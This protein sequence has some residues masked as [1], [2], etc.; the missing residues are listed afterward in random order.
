MPDAPSPNSLARSGVA[1]KSA[2]AI[3]VAAFALAAAL[4][5]TGC[6]HEGRTYK[7][8]SAEKLV[9]KQQTATRHIAEA[10]KQFR[11]ASVSLRA[12][13]TSHTRALAGQ[14]EATRRLALLVPAVETLALKAPAELQAEFADLSA[15]V[16]ALSAEVEKNTGEMTATAQLLRETQAAQA[17]GTANLEQG[18]AAIHEINST[19]APAHFADVEKLAAQATAASDREADWHNKH[20]ALKRQSWTRRIL[21]IAAAVAVLGLVFLW[22]SARIAASGARAA[23]AAASAV[24]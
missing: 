12:A 15:Q 11:Q 8:P 16:R 10:G 1:V 9:A 5:L 13:Q 21:G 3:L 4:Y 22:I 14:A 19:L 20:D 23:A 17:T 7:A 6:S 24:R 2:S 18:T